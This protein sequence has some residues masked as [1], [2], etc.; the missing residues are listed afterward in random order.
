MGGLLWGNGMVGWVKG[1]KDK[2]VVM[3]IRIG[4]VL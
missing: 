2:V 1:I 3:G 4:L